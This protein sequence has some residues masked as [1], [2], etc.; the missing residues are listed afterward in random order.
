MRGLH[1]TLAKP[2]GV[3]SAAVATRLGHSNERV[4]EQ[5]YIA[6]EAKQGADQDRVLHLLSGGKKQGG[7]RRTIVAQPLFGCGEAD[8]LLMVSRTGP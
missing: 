1:G 2:A 5:S 8:D 6:P 4:S 3:T 7:Y